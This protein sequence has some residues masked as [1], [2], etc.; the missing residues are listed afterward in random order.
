MLAV[1][2]GMP[3]LP[4]LLFSALLGFTGWRMS[5]QPAGG[6]GGRESLETLTRTITETSEQQVS[7]ETIPL[8]E[9]ISLSL[10][11]KLVAL[12]DKAQGNPLTQ[13]I[14]GVRQVISD[15]NGVLLPEIRIRENFRLKPSQYAIF[16][17]GI[18]A[19]EADIPADKLMALPSSETY[20][21]ID[22]VQGN[23]PAYGM[24]VTLDPGGAESEGAEYGVSGDRQRQRDR[25][26]CK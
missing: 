17:N 1:V 11:Y 7:W 14:R 6:G 2:P 10:G 8:I 5:K 4:F 12:V 15:G 16:I 21:E 23:D 18:K 19:D 13:R 3:H 20:G 9:P 24:P 22:G 26:P 25:Y